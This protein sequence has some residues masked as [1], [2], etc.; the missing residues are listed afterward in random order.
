MKALCE[1]LSEARKLKDITQDSLATEMN[2]TRQ[3]VSR[4]ENGK[5]LPDAETLKRLSQVLSYDFMADE[6]IPPTADNTTPQINSEPEPTAAPRV[7]APRI[8]RSVLLCAIFLI[9]GLAA[10]CL[11][12]AYSFPH[13][14]QYNA[15]HTP[16]NASSQISAQ[17][18]Y[19]PEVIGEAYLSINATENPVKAV[20]TSDGNAMW[21]YTFVV[22]NIGELTFTA[23]RVEQQVIADDGKC[24]PLGTTSAADMH[25]GDGTILPG[26]EV[27]VRSGLPIQPLKLIHVT[28]YGSD[29]NG[30]PLSFE[31]EAIL[32]KEIAE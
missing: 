7:T 12:G 6:E 17:A 25:W 9:V 1:Q 16:S 27:T 3:A 30:Q 23:E 13:K 2:V 4:W 26:C 31:G 18:P 20:R 15:V 28:V 14:A 32:V 24:Y 22:K 19:K 5:S 29:A 8:N 21:L 11:I 10:G